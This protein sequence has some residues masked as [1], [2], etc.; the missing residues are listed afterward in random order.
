MSRRKV[1]PLL[2]EGQEYVARLRRLLGLI[3]DAAAERE[4]AQRIPQIP[5]HREP[6]PTFAEMMAV[7][8]RRRSR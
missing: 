7:V 2:T 4:P 6:G 8:N 1:V 3:E 5:A